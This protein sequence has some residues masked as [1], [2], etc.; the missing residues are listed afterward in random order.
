MKKTAR[1]F[2]L[3]DVLDEGVEAVAAVAAPFLGLLWLTALPLR[4]AQAHFVFQVA[5][6]G[7]EAARHGRYLGELALV[8]AV[9]L[10]PWAWGRAVFVRACRLGLE[11]QPPGRAALR[12]G[13]LPFAGF[14]Y[15]T[16]L[17]EALAWATAWTV[18][19]LPLFV[20]MGALAAATHPFIEKP[21]LLDPLRQVFRH[22]TQALILVGLLVVMVWA[23]LVAGVNL[24]VLFQAGVWLAGAWPGAEPG[25]W[26]ALLDV[27]NP[28]YWL[29]LICG[30]VLAVEPYLLGTVT[31]YVHKLRARSTGEDLRLWFER[32]RRAVAA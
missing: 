3:L 28:R 24:H 31:V 10:L 14:L 20:L 1:A 18:V 4:L 32:L 30:A 23:L 22:G 6:L 19:A 21:G 25:R 2:S 13:A 26:R 15:V 17:V 27:H 16:A 9:L 12:V 29:V 8:Q 11:G 5:Q 7:P